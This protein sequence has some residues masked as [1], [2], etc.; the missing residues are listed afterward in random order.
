MGYPAGLAEKRRDF[1]TG[2]VVIHSFLQ[3]PHEGADLRF[4]K[5]TAVTAATKD[6]PLGG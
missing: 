4:W 2:S 3:P 6:D 1:L 5:L